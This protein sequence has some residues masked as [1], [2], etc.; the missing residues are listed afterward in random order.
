ML[1]LSG[2]IFEHLVL[3]L[4]CPC[5]YYYYKSLQIDSTICISTLIGRHVLPMWALLQL[6]AN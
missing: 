6:V 5:G 3:A 2:Q 1:F 4:S